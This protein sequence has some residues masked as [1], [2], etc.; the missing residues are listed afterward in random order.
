MPAHD[1]TYSPPSAPNLPNGTLRTMLFE[2]YT[3]DASQLGDSVATLAE[4][5]ST[6]EESYS[7]L[8]ESYS[9]LEESYSSLDK[10]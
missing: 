1:K 9:V 2:K 4:R 6:L 7:V 8:K 3:L 10:N 5:V